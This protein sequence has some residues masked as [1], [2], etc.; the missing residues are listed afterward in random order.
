MYELTGADGLTL[1]VTVNVPE[2]IAPDGGA[3]ATRPV[4]RTKYVPTKFAPF[5]V[6]VPDEPAKA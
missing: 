2:E 4:S 3:S 5:T 1:K 6:I